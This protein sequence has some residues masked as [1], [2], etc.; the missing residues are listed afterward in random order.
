MFPL[1]HF[2]RVSNILEMNIKTP[3]LQSFSYPTSHAHKPLIR[4]RHD[5]LVD[6][7]IFQ[8]PRNDEHVN[9]KSFHFPFQNLF[10][11]LISFLLFQVMDGK[12][13]TFVDKVY[14]TCCC[15]PS[16]GR[17]LQQSESTTA[18]VSV[19]KSPTISRRRV[20]K[21]YGG[22]SSRSLGRSQI[23]KIQPGK[24]NPCF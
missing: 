17:P 3:Q 19:G 20:I 10:Y 13:S 9:R 14:H 16:W 1:I 15:C 24:F 2:P 22:A 6:G 5:T 12:L 7:N 21:G 4:L 11:S 8:V 18:I 23:I